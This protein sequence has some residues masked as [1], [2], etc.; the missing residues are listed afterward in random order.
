MAYVIIK[1]NAYSLGFPCPST[2]PSLFLF[3]FFFFEEQVAIKHIRSFASGSFNAHR[4][5]FLF[6]DFTE[7]LDNWAQSIKRKRAAMCINQK[8]A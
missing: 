7:M 8:I 5:T 6:N 3:F 4:G 1:V 2:P